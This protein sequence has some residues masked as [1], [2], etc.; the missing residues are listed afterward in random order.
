LTFDSEGKMVLAMARPLRIQFE[1]A[2]YHV[3]SRGNERQSVFRSEEDRQQFVTLLERSCARYQVSLLAF[4]FLSN[5][6]HLLAQTH[7]GNLSRWMHWLM[8]TYT[9]WFN[10]RYTRSG[11][12]FQGR[13]KSFL[14]EKGGYLLELSRYLHLNPVRGKL[15]GKGTPA[16]RR[17]RL[18]KYV[19][20]SYGG[21]AGL[22]KPLG[23]VREEMVLGEMGGP[24]RGRA[25]RYRRFV[26]EG[27]LRELSSPMETLQWQ[28][29]LGSESFV[30]RMRDRLSRR[31]ADHE[32]VTGLRR[33]VAVLAA[34]EVLLA[35]AEFYGV[36][37]GQLKERASHGWEARNVAIWLLWEKCGLSQRQIG[38]LFGGLKY[39][40]VAQ[41]LRRLKP[42]SRQ[43]AET[44]LK[45][46]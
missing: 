24:R 32:E 16:E 2:I 10:W 28:A 33:A 25:R 5:H 23:F 15:L 11:H 42:K 21:Y 14:V 29:V 27:L 18:R 4:V 1:D 12:L 45:Q 31:G 19:W 43:C 7:R 8:V 22:R 9:S 40:A 46:M 36:G 20:S 39:G 38:Q 26:E 44:L 35:V 3:M 30:R 13:Y 6:F 41:R 34:E 37:V 17:Q